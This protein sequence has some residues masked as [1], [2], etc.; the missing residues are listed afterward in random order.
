MAGFYVE[1]GGL[2]FG[3]FTPEKIREM[4]AN[5]TITEETHLSRDRSVWKTADEF[6][7]LRPPQQVR[8]SDSG[9]SGAAYPP[10]AAPPVY[11]PSSSSPS[12]PA[13]QPPPIQCDA[14]PESAP[15]KSAYGKKVTLNDK[16]KTRFNWSLWC[17]IL[18][19]CVFTLNV[20]LSYIRKGESDA[21]LIVLGAMFP[22]LILIFA[23]ETLKF[24]HGMWRSIP[25]EF[26]RTTPDV[27]VG[28]LFVP[29]WRV[30]WL[31]AVLVDAAKGINAALT[32]R[33]LTDYRA[34]QV[35]TCLAA[36]T[37]VCL[38]VA[39]VVSLLASVSMALSA[40]K[41]L[42]DL[43]LVAVWGGAPLFFITSILYFYLLW[44]TGSVGAILLFFLMAQAKRAV[45]PLNE[46]AGIQ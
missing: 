30:Y 14:R 21:F 31:F 25:K 5:G 23:I 6:G 42:D 9:P 7:E 28:F 36:T 12:E 15:R 32:D 33:G 37:S 35:S 44:L 1:R 43:A 46:A 45:Y 2:A 39:L 34:P 19:W 16:L 41:D 38:V 27:A 3:P 18:S 29:F 22:I 24:L 4:L 17:F 10:P 13:V 8:Q 40:L 20:I 11:S 26:A